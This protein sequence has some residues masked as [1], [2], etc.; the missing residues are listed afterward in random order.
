MNFFLTFFENLHYPSLQVSDLL[1]GREP[2]NN[3]VYCYLLSCTPKAEGNYSKTKQNQ[4][5]FNK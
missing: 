4:N 2:Q 3:N 5:I 1:G